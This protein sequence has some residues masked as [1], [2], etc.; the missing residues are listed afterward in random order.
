MTLVDGDDVCV[1]NTNRQLPALADTIGRPK[2]A[3]MAERV[4]LISP[5]CRVEAAPEYYT[6]ANS[7]VLLSH[8]FDFIVDCMDR[9]IIKAHLIH[10]CRERKL[11]LLTCGAAGGRRDPSAIRPSDLGFAG[12]DELLR[13]V[14][15][16]LRREHGWPPGHRGPGKPMGVRCVFSNEKPVFPRMDGTC[17]AE[18]EPESSLRM[19]C[20]SGFG[21]AAFVTGVFGFIVAGEVVKHLAARE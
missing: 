10:S 16:E 21:A 14:R 19:D 5:T 20:G 13:G 17:S 3:V 1:T 4:A 8:G 7:D 18:P 2:V 11:A 9:A 15:R 6:K 12:N